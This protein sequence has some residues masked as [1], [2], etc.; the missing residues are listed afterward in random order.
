VGAPLGRLA[1]VVGSTGFDVGSQ[2]TVCC[3]TSCW[4]IE[5]GVGTVSTH[6]TTGL[7]RGGLAEGAG[8]RFGHGKAGACAGQG[9]AG[10]IIG[11]VLVVLLVRAVATRLPTNRARVGGRWQDG[12]R[13]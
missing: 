10:A 6:L 4:T 5:G 13:M 12:L 1:C 7:P 8:A 9:R 11:S 2:Y 3:S